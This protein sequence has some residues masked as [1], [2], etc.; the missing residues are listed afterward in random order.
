VIL[1]RSD[2]LAIS[3]LSKLI[4]KS[5][6]WIESFMDAYDGLPNSHTSISGH[7]MGFNIRKHF[8]PNKDLI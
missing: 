3:T 1:A 2:D 6:S 5:A 8:P 7:V 4:D